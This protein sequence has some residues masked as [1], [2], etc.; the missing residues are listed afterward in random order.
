M[1]LIKER[2]RA[3]PRYEVPQEGQLV[4]LNQNEFP[5]DVPEVVKQEV[6]ARLASTPWQRYP[7]GQAAELTRAIAGYAGVSPECVLV[8]NASNELIQAV[9]AA[10]CESG[11]RVVTVTPG[12]AVYSRV[13]SI[14]GAEVREVP[15]RPDFS[16]DA[17]AM[18]EAALGADLVIFASPNNPTGT[19]MPS[20]AL[21]Q[22]V[23]T[24]KCLVCVD[25][26]YFEFHGET[27]LPLLN[28]HDNLVILRTFSKAWRLAG[29]RLGY[30]LGPAAVV[31]EIAK[32]KLPF[33]VGIL[34]QIAG[35]VLLA[36]KELLERAIAE[37]VD[38]REKLYAQLQGV[39]GLEVVP[40]RANFLL[41]RHQEVPAARLFVALRRRGVLVR[42]FGGTLSQWL[43]VT[44]GTAR[45]NRS[46]VQALVACLEELA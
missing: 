5:A 36:H 12:F 22:L 32:A 41:F 27:A 9:V 6:L 1:R 28:G 15:L 17:E 43:R 16:F 11:D 3:L 4:K 18:A 19:W 39:A 25:E 40:S 2:V 44:V 24:C 42:S 21:A 37:V 14:L 33:S 30:L 23:P 45:E 26:A 8:G 35:Q 20:T 13:A 31:A 7:D 10:T 34:Q 29:F 46:F 38:Q